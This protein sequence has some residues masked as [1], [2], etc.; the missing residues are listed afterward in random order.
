MLWFREFGQSF[1]KYFLCYSR[2]SE[3]TPHIS[4][5]SWRYYLFWQQRA[6][7][8][9]TSWVWRDLD[10]TFCLNRLMWH[11][12]GPP[13]NT[14]TGERS[15]TLNPQATWCLRSRDIFL[16][17]QERDLQ[18]TIPSIACGRSYSLILHWEGKGDLV[19]RLIDLIT[20]RV[21]LVIPI[22]NLFT[23]SPLTNLGGLRIY[24]TRSSLGCRR[25]VLA[26]TARRVWA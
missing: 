5:S 10:Y 18:K 17:L 22:I 4:C 14:L 8:C 19:S 1:S 6:S 20:H 26:Y 9:L 15:S 21:T 7:R 13:L 24:W 3:Y 12:W 23:K 16:G 25:C 11:H 2:Q